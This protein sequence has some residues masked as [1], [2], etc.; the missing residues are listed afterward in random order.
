[1]AISMYQVSVPV[2]LKMLGNLSAILDKGAVFAEAKKVDPENERMAALYRQHVLKE[3]PAE[4]TIQIKGLAS[5]KKEP[6]QEVLH[7]TPQQ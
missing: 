5:K 2:F 7:N 4:P 3:A 6:V 1:M